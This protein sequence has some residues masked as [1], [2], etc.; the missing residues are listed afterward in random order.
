MDVVTL[1]FFVGG[2]IL[3]IAGAEILV[4]GASKLAAAIGISPL[5]IGLTVVAYG[6]SAPELAVSVQSAFSGQ[7][8]LALGNVVG[9]NIFNVLFILGLSALIA[10]L[11]VSQQLVRLE[12][13]LMIGVS[14]L[15]AIL[16]LDGNL[17][18]LDGALLFAGVVTY[19]VFAI[20][21]SRKESKQIQD[22]YA[23]EYGNGKS[24]SKAQWQ[25]NLIFIIAGLGLLVWGSRWLVNGAVAIAQAFG[26]SE[27]IIG[28]T[29][30]AAGT[31]LPEVAT[32][33]IASLRGE[34]DIAVGN[35]V[36]SNI[37]NILS[38]LGLTG[39]VAPNGVN[40]S[41]AALRFDIPVMLAVAVACL[42]IFFTG[43]MI[44][45]WEGALF[46]AYYIAYMLYLIL[47][48]TQHDALPAFSSVMMEFV[49]PLTVITLLIV[50]GRSIRAKRRGAAA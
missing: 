14:L 16:A 45:R 3:L 9:S 28:L 18:R 8:E 21:Q 31:S 46:L 32:S 7:A 40:V 30:V 34:R 48:A 6:T 44:A 25:I 10:P 24:Q 2:L 50:V 17:G 5:V 19:T 12:V 26:L 47:D 38:V 20:R 29:I 27:L 43:K 39:L 41:S 4:R 33:I 15:M 35:V 49:V 13:P 37:F 23:K 36:G 11:V 1:A 42:P 22:E